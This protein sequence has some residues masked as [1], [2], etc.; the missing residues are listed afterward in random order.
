MIY[1]CTYPDP[2]WASRRYTV[3]EHLCTPTDLATQGWPV[4]T[5]AALASTAVV[6]RGGCVPFG[7]VP[8][9]AM[10]CLRPRLPPNLG[11]PPKGLVIKTH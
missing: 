2:S 1:V 6:G 9:P 8:F 5:L 10:P 7:R 11:S 4:L 3:H